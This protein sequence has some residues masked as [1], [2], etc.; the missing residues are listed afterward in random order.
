MIDN[1]TRTIIHIRVA[2]VGSVQWRVPGVS[3]CEWCV[4]SAWA[5]EFPAVAVSR[6]KSLTIVTVARL[7]LTRDCR[8]TRLDPAERDR[9]R[10]SLSASHLVGGI[11]PLAGAGPASAVITAHTIPFPHQP[12][13]TYVLVATYVSRKRMGYHMKQPHLLWQAMVSSCEQ[14]PEAYQLPRPRTYRLRKQ[15]VRV[16]RPSSCS[17]LKHAPDLR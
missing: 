15:A 1:R 6:D 11:C 17:E 10:H 2:T 13:T 12:S 8:L 5:S 7:A 14:Y 3:M 4:C 16:R 9:H